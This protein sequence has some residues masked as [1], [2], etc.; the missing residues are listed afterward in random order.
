L[1]HIPS[2]TIAQIEPDLAGGL[3]GDKAYSALFDNSK[4]KR[5]VPS[6]RISIPFHTGMRRSLEWYE[7]HPDLKRADPKTE[8]L[9]ERI[10]AEW[11]RMVG[12]GRRT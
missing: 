1:V 8:S 6:F 12:G 2:D 10:L 9:I 4:I 11:H 5:L 3:L 7:K